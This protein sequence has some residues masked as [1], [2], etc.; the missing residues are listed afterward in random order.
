VTPTTES[1][2]LD[3]RPHALFLT[4][5]RKSLGLPVCNFRRPTAERLREPSFKLHD[6]AGGTDDLCPAGLLVTQFSVVAASLPA[7]KLFANASPQI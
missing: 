6:S 2:E 4:A 7:L 3:E 5:G 1:E